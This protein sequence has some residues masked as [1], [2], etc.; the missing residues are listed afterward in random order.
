MGTLILQ[1]MPAAMVFGALGYA[2]FAG[3]RLYRSHGFLSLLALACTFGGLA[4][5]RLLDRAIRLP[6]FLDDWVSYRGGATA[7]VSSRA[8]PYLAVLSTEVALMLSCAAVIVVVG[9]L[10]IRRDALGRSAS[11]TT[12][13]KIAPLAGLV[14]LALALTVRSKLAV[15]VA[16]VL[17]KANLI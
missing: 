2:L 11:A 14:A 4:V 13:A 6:K 9:A 8:E 3:V 16:F 7:T 1:V 5:G 17:A 12:F 15:A 10:L